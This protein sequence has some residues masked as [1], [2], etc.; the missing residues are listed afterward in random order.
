MKK[1][2]DLI[3]TE[4]VDNEIKS[5]KQLYEQQLATEYIS[6]LKKELGLVNNIQEQKVVKTFHEVSF[7]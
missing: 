3:E 7:K 6:N 4:K 5:K 2:S 1:F